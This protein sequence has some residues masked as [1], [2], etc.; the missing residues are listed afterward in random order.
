MVSCA[1]S[2]PI[3]DLNLGSSVKV[4]GMTDN[5]VVP[6]HHHDYPGFSGLSGLLAAATMT[7]GR[8]GDAR[9]AAELTHLG[10][11]DLV[12]DVGCGPGAAARHAARVGAR[13]TGV[14]PATVMLLVA[15]A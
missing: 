6:N 1:S 14:D 12:V 8:G 11:D 3:L 5:T 7:T 10:P 9:L 13:V 2:M 15:R 4:A